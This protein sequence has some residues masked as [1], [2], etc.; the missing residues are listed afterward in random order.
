ME[1]L[2]A[3]HAAQAALAA[4]D[5]VLQAALAQAH[6]AAA[7]VTLRFV[8]LNDLVHLIANT[9][10]AP[11]GGIRVAVHLL[12]NFLF[13]YALKQIRSPSLRH[14]ASLAVGFLAIQFL[15]GPFWIHVLGMVVSSYL[16]LLFL[17]PGV[18]CNVAVFVVELA[19]LCVAHYYRMTHADDAA[20]DV[21]APAMVLIIKITS[22]TFNL[23]DAHV[24]AQRAKATGTVIGMPY[25]AAGVF[26]GP[27]ALVPRP[28]PAFAVA[29][30]GNGG[31]GGSGDAASGGAAAGAAGNGFLAD[32]GSASFSPTSGSPSP[33]AASPAVS[34]VLEGATLAAAP[35]T[36]LPADA[37]ARPSRA[38][39]IMAERRKLALDRL[40]SP[41]EYF[42]YMYLFTTV[43]AGPA[44]PYR[45]YI[46]AVEGGA[47]ARERALAV[48]RTVASGRTATAPDALSST[49]PA[50][51][52]LAA[53][54]VYMVLHVVGG[55]AFPLAALWTDAPTLLGDSFP[56]RLLVLYLAVLFERCKY[57][58]AWTMAEG[59]S[60]MAEFGFNGRDPATGR[61][62]WDGIN[63]M[64]VLTFELSQSPRD[65]SVRWNRVTGEWLRRYVF[66]RI[67]PGPT[68]LF[69][70]YLVAAFWH[71]FYPGY[72]I[73]FLSAAV[74][75][76]AIKSVRS[77][78]RPLFLR[79]PGAKRFY[80]AAGVVVTA[81]T[82]AYFGSAFMALYVDRAL[83]I[84]RRVH[85]V[86]HVILLGAAL[87]AL[88]VP[89]P[90]RSSRHHHHHHHHHGKRRA[91]HSAS[92]PS[93][94]KSKAT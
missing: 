89:P 92:P 54:L 55:A 41:L 36:D 39:A 24:L 1:L 93:P 84:W 68:Q 53:A 63:N 33:L 51:R 23:Y 71:G 86:G 40:P 90:P 58:F 69:A 66:E 52:A 25:D 83:A 16:L 42:G 67:P 19:W 88:V 12:L 17:P 2:P 38:E 32:S 29:S 7:P 6:R 11:V 46:D 80:D 31:G 10:G 87:F 62:R 73:F 61:A 76:A 20:A 56:A 43:Y 75:Q 79:S 78:V 22:L 15:L 65:A 47:L 64:D 37:P 21:S 91:S 34:A 94:S 82:I 9:V 81:I 3:V 59:A 8:L 74:L 30:A 48:A 35:G 4:V 77:H 18:T 26:G 45:E 14:L 28:I 85:Y 13:A 50:L 72:Y 60:I 57:Y 27:H 44:F 5:G 70:L 49:A